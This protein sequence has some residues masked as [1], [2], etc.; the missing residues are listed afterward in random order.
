M[1]KNLEPN[2]RPRH[3]CTCPK[4]AKL[5]DIQVIQDAQARHEGQMDNAPINDT[6]DRPPTQCRMLS[7]HPDWSDSDNDKD[8]Q[9]RAPIA[10][11]PVKNP[12]PSTS[13]VREEAPL[14]RPNTYPKVLTFGRGNMAPLASWNKITLGCRCG[15]NIN[16][17]S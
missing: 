13:Y 7:Y 6:Q 15:L 16:H 2:Y 8:N 5:S 14:R 11:T 9:A 12:Q 4:L 3:Y 10:Y 17:I 1:D